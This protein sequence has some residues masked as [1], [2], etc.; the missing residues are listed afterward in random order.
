METKKHIC[1]SAPLYEGSMLLGIVNTENEVS[2]L[3]EPMEIDEA[4]IESANKGRV[5]EQRFR[6]ANKCVK[7]GCAQW[8]GNQCG[9][10][11]RVLE[12]IDQSIMKVELPECKIRP[13]CRWFSQEGSNACRV[14]PLIKFI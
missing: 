6:F 7:S 12:N 3:A 13:E 5:P 11:K 9:V 1:P 8:T 2:I 4:F 14:C 10:I